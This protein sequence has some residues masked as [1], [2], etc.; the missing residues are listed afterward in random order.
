MA[1]GSEG[2]MVPEAQDVIGFSKGPSRVCSWVSGL[3]YSQGVEGKGIGT[4]G[5]EALGFLDA[6]EQRV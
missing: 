1:A 2:S 4:L 6:E 3:F 5:V